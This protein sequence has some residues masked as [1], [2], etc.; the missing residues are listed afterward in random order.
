MVFWNLWV[1]S[2]QATGDPCK[3]TIFAD[4]VGPNLTLIML[5]N[6][7]GFPEQ[8]ST[9]AFK[10]HVST[11]SPHRGRGL[12]EVQHAM[13]ALHGKAHLVRQVSGELRVCLKFPREVQ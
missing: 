3:I 5:D 11:K 6:G 8:L 4:I 7:D 12:L 9:V 10:D 1:N 2:H 13:E